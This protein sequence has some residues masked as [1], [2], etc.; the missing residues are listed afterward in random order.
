MRHKIMKSGKHSLAVIVPAD[1]VHTLGIKA[2]DNV[3]IATNSEKGIVNLKF[4]GAMQLP[5]SLSSP[6]RTILKRHKV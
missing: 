1:F 2:G 5:L 6:P 4:S 3:E